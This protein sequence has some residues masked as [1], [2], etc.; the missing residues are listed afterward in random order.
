MAKM[1]KYG[2][3]EEYLADQPKD[4]R[5]TLESVRRSVLAVVPD[6]T[7]KIGYGMPGFYVDGHPLVYYAAF[8]EHCSLFPASGG[9]IEKFADE[10]KGYGLAKGTI[11]FPIGEPLPPPLVEKIVKVKL[12][13][14]RGSD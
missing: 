4:V 12:E 2:T 13:E 9:V 11:R 1:K 7:E 6:A 3:V 8:K 5:E 10:L 14:L